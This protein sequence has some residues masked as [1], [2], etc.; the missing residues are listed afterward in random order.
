MTYSPGRLRRALMGSLVAIAL[1][2]SGLF[3]QAPAGSSSTA[4]AVDC[5]RR[6]LA[7]G[8]HLPAGH[9][10]SETEKYPKQLLDDHLANWGPW[11]LYNTSSNGTTSSSYIS[12]G[13]LARSWNLAANLVTIQVGGE[14]SSIVDL[15]DSCFDKLKDHDFTGANVCAAIVLANQSAFTQLQLNLTTILQQYRVL[16]ARNPNL[17]V[18]VIGYPNPYPDAIEV[19]PK[20]VEL[21]IPL[22]DTIATCGIR[23]A[24][25]PPA[26]VTL[27][28]AIKKL[29]SS[30]KDDVANFQRAANG[31]RF[32]FV[33]TYDKLRDHC[34]KMEVTIKTKVEHPEEN[35]A[36]HEHD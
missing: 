19:T 18:A 15:I 31:Q 30:I 17:V 24:Q 29:N 4:V 16:A 22:M 36:V 10:V 12:G 35:G 3:L 14:N 8:D 20:I 6:Y 2:T 23:W 13:Q 34:M 32:V 21:C 28:L 26:L 25:L 1:A 11:C 5:A 7:G 9:E 27:D 33:D